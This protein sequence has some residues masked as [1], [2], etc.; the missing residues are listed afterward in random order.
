MSLLDDAKVLFGDMRNL[1]KE[2]QES[3]YNSLDRISEPTGITLF[4]IEPRNTVKIKGKI[5]KVSRAEEK[6]VDKHDMFIEKLFYDYE[7]D[8]LKKM[9]VECLNNDKFTESEKLMI[10]SI[11]ENTLV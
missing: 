7:I 3:L 9:C 6:L 5:T 1:T 4:D 8:L 11:L 2:E 10:D